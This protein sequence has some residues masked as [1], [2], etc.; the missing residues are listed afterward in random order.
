M[1]YKTVS[2]FRVDMRAADLVG[3]SGSDDL[4]GK[5]GLVGCVEDL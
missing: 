5:M 1:A 2:M 4:M 3:G